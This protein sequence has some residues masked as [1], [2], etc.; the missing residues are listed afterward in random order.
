[1]KSKHSLLFLLLFWFAIPAFSQYRQP[2]ASSGGGLNDRIY[3]GGGGG[4]SGGSNFLNVGLSP[5]IGYKVTDDF[6]AG[7]QLTYQ[8]VKYFQV[9]WSNYGGGP[10]VRY[11]ITEK[12]FGYSQYEYLNV[13]VSSGE[14]RFNFTSLFVGLGY[15]EPI[16]R[17]VA[18]NITALY[19]VLYGDG[20][21]TPYR[22]PLQFRVGIVA[23]LF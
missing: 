9:S 3:F 21:N 18:F 5:L 13:G 22:S 15:T 17:N 14:E 2:S 12:L 20:T 16:G 10:F 1:M 19:N 23:G 6:S 4:F 7:I 8:Y 11:N